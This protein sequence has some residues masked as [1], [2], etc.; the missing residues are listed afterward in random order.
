[1]SSPA[2]EA[3]PTWVP[4]ALRTSRDSNGVVVVEAIG[5][6]NLRSLQP[7]AHELTAQLAGHHATVR[8]DLRAIT[9]LD[10][11]GALMLWRAWGKR[12][13]EY[14]ILRPEHEVFFAHL[15]AGLAFAH[16]LPRNIERRRLLWAGGR[17]V[18]TLGEHMLQAISLLGKVSLEIKRKTIEEQSARGLY[19]YSA[20]YLRN[21]KE[22]TGEYWFNH[23]NTVGLVGMNEACRCM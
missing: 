8:W 3:A 21:I 19:P 7:L 11:A 1:M 16:V 20:H 15:E 17:A 2:N 9:R 12:R 14:L 13:V 6:W 4:P 22:R 5:A 10:H 18:V 23:F